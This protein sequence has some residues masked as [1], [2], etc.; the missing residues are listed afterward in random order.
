MTE[1]KN[2]PKR[3]PRQRTSC[4]CCSFS[5]EERDF[6]LSSG[7]LV[8]GKLYRTTTAQHLYFYDAQ[9]HGEKLRQAQEKKEKQ[10]AL[11]SVTTVTTAG[12]TS[13][14]IRLSEMNVFCAAGELIM[15]IKGDNL[16]ISPC[17][18][19]NNPDNNKC[20]STAIPQ[21]KIVSFSFLL[22]TGKLVYKEHHYDEFVNPFPYKGMHNSKYNKREFKLD[23][24]LQTWLEK[25]ETT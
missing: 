25:V 21:R 18:C 2:K 20:P 22:S 24:L 12:S 7:F 9:K 17:T 11:P 8:P 10:Q 3:T 4:S 23:D 6:T 1:Q 5:A 13:P 14:L 19:C 16:L 15:F